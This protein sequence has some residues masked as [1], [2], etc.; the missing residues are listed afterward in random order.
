MGGLVSLAEKIEFQFGR[1][2]RHH[3]FGGEALELLFQYGAWRVF[4]II[5]VVVERIANDESCAG[6]PGDEA[7]GRD[8][9]LHHEVAIAARPARRFV[10]GHRFHIGVD[11][12][13][14]IA[15][16]GFVHCRVEE[17]AGL[18]PLADETPLHVRHGHYDGINVATTDEVGKRIEG[19]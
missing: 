3:A 7:Q 4:D 19:K 14:V 8:V 5:A 16:V 17:V 6:H 13:Q 1:C 15:G 2:V 11:G 10:A 9:R 12:E 18:H